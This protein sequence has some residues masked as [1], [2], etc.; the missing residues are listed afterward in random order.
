MGGGS[1]LCLQIG[2]R[3]SYDFDIF[4]PKPLTP[5]FFHQVTEV[6]GKNLEKL[7][8]TQDQL[9]LLLKNKIG[10]TFLHYYYH[11]LFPLVPTEFIP[12]YDARDIALDKAN[13]I[14]RRGLW[15]DYVD[16]YFLLKKGDVRLKELLKLGKKKF[17]A[18]F[19]PK[20]FL[21]QLTYFGD[22]E[23]YTIEYVSRQ[24]NPE[25]IKKF[26]VNAVKQFKRKTLKFR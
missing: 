6:L 1:A 18:A 9:N 10:I 19:A 8:D 25:E 2:H 20:L 5:Q 15:R 21:E 26:L 4:S 13:T 17:G 14:G 22:I 7:V 12:L 24:I 3:K 23:E 11:P 16:L